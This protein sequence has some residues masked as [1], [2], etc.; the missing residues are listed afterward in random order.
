MPSRQ[1]GVDVAAYQNTSMS[2]YH[3]AGAKYM[4][5]KLTEG[6]SYFNPKAH[7]QIESAHAHH[8][9]VHA[10][11][12][13]TFSDSVSRAKKEAKFFVAEAKRNNISKKR[14]LWLD[15]ETGDGNSVVGSKA[16]NTKAI[17]AFMKVCHNAD[18]KVGLYSGTYVL[19]QHVD[20]STIVKKYGTCI[21]VASYATMGRIDNPDFG[22]FP[23]MNGV[24]MWQ[25]T[26]NWHD[27]N[28]DGNVA[29][30][31]LHYTDGAKTTTKK[32]VEKPKPKPINKT[33]IVYAP[34]INHN[35]NWKIRLLD[36]D[37]HYTKYIR[38]NTRWKYFDVK[39]I[40]GMKCY[41]LGTDTQWVPAKYT[42][43]I[44]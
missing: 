20:T 17:M 23:S 34:V 39:I 43:I 21:W 36:S 10:Y 30:I 25:F 13:A 42:K 6:S 27:L 44:E 18:Y 14:Y 8:M 37:G 12:F 40:K 19:K 38:T 4:I 3:V 5:V 1:Y 33:G 32:P 7:Y 16:A 41:Q 28:V 2:S 26:D 15:W 31:N 22:Y 24:A 11:H 29:L 35:P 9:Y